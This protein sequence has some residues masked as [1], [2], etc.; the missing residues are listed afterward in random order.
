RYVDGPGIDEPIVWYEGSN[1]SDRRWLVANEQNSVI[2]VTDASGAASS[3]NSYDEYG[4]PNASNAGRFQYTGQMWLPEASLYH[5]KARAYS[6]AL[7]RFMQ[8]DPIGQAAGTNIYLYVQNDP[9]NQ[10]DPSG[11]RYCPSG[12]RPQPDGGFCVQGVYTRGSVI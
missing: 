7:G 11:L 4:V 10:M 1:T 5:Y 2:A 6:P 12:D 3:I 9:L 8:T